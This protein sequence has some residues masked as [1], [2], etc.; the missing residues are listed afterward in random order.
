VPSP[1]E[2]AVARKGAASNPSRETCGGKKT[3]KTAHRAVPSMLEA[4]ARRDAY[5]RTPH[6]QRPALD[7]TQRGIMAELWAIVIT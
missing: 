6:T 4:L 7:L 2:E 5:S 3:E 1:L